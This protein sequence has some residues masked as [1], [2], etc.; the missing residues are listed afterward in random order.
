MK[1]L[2]SIMG[3]IACGLLLAGCGGH[4]SPKQGAAQYSTLISKPNE[5]VCYEGIDLAYW[6]DHSSN[7][8]VVVISFAT[9]SSPFPQLIGIGCG[10]RNGTCEYFQLHEGKSKRDIP[11]IEGDL[12]SSGKIP[13]YYAVDRHEA[14]KTTL[15]FDE[16]ERLQTAVESKSFAE[17]K[18]IVTKTAEQSAASDADRPR[19]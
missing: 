2:G 6:F 1:E 10:F 17:A 9:S 5:N 7:P 16:F 12:V 15:T 13:V 11:F 19:R 3:L 18:H 14:T 8:A 4:S